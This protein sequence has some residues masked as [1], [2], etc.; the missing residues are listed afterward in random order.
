MNDNNCKNC[1]YE[2]RAEDDE[3]CQ[4][5]YD[6]FCGKQFPQPTEWKPKL[7]TEYKEAE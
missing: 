1:K 7:E 6:S 5:C 2:D 4:R 3:P